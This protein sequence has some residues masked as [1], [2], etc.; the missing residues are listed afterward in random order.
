MKIRLLGILFAFLCGPLFG[1]SLAWEPVTEGIRYCEIP[2]PILSETGENRLCLLELI[3]EKLEFEL[4]CA[5]ENRE[6]PKTV[7][8]WSESR[9]FVL[10]FNA[11]MYK[12]DQPLRSRGFLKNK[13]HHNQ[14]HFH[15]DYRGVLAFQALDSLQK[16]AGLFDLECRSWDSLRQQYHCLAQGLRMLDCQSKPLSWNKKKQRCSMMLMAQDSLGKLFLVFCRSPFSHNQMISFLK[17]LPLGLRHALY[18]EGGPETSLFLHSGNFRLE[19]VGSYVS[20]S[21]E[22]DANDHF[23]KLPN[24]IGVKPRQQKAPR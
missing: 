15:P 14:A 21:Y 20:D 1:Q 19:K 22:T 9:G 10:A 4:V 12:L 17:D 7:Q 6:E 2:C 24:V 3:P 8:E 18:L 23:W 5:S 11:S 16:P 13:N